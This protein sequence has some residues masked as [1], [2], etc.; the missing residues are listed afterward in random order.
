MAVISPIPT[1][2]LEPGDLK[3]YAND[4]DAIPNRA[5]G[6]IAP[7][8]SLSFPEVAAKVAAEATAEP[9]ASVPAPKPTKHLALWEQEEFG[10]RDIVD[11]INPLQHIPIVATLYRHMTGEKI[12]AVPRVIGGALWGRLGGFV[13]ALV[14]TAVDWFTGKDIGDH[15]YAML[16]GDPADKPEATSVAN[17]TAVPANRP[18]GLAVE[19]AASVPLQ[20][21]PPDIKRGAAALPAA[22][23]VQSFDSKQSTPLSAIPSRLMPTRVIPAVADHV[24][25]SYYGASRKP[26]DEEDDARRLRVTV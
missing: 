8:R 14:N 17:S 7:N 26:R 5:G 20:S 6:A 25:L 11:I 24:L 9:V 18:T 22:A 23:P 19:K 12:G 13:S 16:F 2:A 15:I 4:V 10:F 3:R 1:T 21:S